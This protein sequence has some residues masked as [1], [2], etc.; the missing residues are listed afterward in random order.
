MNV[1]TITNLIGLFPLY[2]YVSDS[3]GSNKTYIRTIYQFCYSLDIE[4]PSIFNGES[5]LIITIQD[6]YGNETFKIISC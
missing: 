3:N 2:I 1:I 5:T 6:I 4:V